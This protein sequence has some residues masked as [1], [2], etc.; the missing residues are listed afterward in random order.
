MIQHPKH[1]KA[2]AY[3]RQLCCLGLSKEAVIPE[4]LRAVQ[5]VLPSN[6]NTFTGVYE[7]LMPAYHILGFDSSEIGELTAIV[8]PSYFTLENRGVAIFAKAC[9]EDFLSKQAAK[10]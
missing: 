8:M 5:T 2:V 7:R 9:F 6:S 4:F 10:T 1:T 3:L